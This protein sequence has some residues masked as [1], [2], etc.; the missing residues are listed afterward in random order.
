MQMRRE[1]GIDVRGTQD[2]TVRNMTK[3]N[4]LFRESYG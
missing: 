1:F 2:K 4:I 3:L